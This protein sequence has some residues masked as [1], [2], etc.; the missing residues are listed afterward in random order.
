VAAQVDVCAVVTEEGVATTAI[1]VMV[2]VAAVTVMLAEPDTFV[3][4]A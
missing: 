1:D 3:K 2:K 4:P